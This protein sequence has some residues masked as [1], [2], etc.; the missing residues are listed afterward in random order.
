[1]AFPILYCSGSTKWII[2]F[3]LWEMKKFSCKM[4]I[5]LL[6]K[7]GITKIIASTNGEIAPQ[8]LKLQKVDL[9]ISDWHFTRRL[10]KKW[11]CKI[12]PN[13]LVRILMYDKRSLELSFPY[14]T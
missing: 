9:I 2:Q 12:L 4:T 3:V 1:M 8:K 7:M 11:T 13:L 10:K 5:E 6:K 14:Q